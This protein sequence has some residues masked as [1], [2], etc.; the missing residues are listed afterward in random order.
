MKKISLLLIFLT[1][2]TAQA[3]IDPVLKKFSNLSSFAQFT[4]DGSDQVNEY[5]VV[6]SE[7]YH[8][9]LPGTCDDYDKKGMLEEFV[10]QL[11]KDLVAAIQIKNNIE[12]VH[13]ES[14]YQFQG[15]DDLVPFLDLR[16]GSEIDNPSTQYL[17]SL[18]MTMTTSDGVSLTVIPMVVRVRDALNRTLFVA[19]HGV[20]TTG[21]A[22][23]NEKGIGIA[24]ETD[25]KT[26]YDSLGRLVKS[27]STCQVR[28]QVNSIAV[29]NSDTNIRI[30]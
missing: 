16:L 14:S 13:V 25:T 3:H 28:S 29:I 4:T 8:L 12:I 19:F 21:G 18:E 24:F 27:S 26:E 11:E 10:N 17:G 5:L 2:M 15:T 1:C 22:F 7:L 30:W 23:Y 20:T 6:R 9:T